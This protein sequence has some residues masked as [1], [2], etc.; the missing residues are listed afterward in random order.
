MAALICWLI[1]NPLIMFLNT[2]IMK[3]GM[4]LTSLSLLLFISSIAQDKTGNLTDAAKTALNPIA[5][6]VKLMLQPNYYIYN[7]GG[8]AINLMT[9]VIIPYNAI[10]I[11]GI[12]S[13]N[14]NIFSLC[15]LEIPITSQTYGS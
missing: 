2:G 3:K 8:N 4:I 1:I 10:L 14:K 15:R 13:K 9:R 5:Q 11:P 6:V 12:R 7:N